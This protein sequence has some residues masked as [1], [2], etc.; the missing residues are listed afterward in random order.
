MRA[1][2]IV[3]LAACHGS[4]SESPPEAS[5]AQC[6]GGDTIVTRKIAYACGSPFAPAAPG[7]MQGGLTLVTSPPNDGRMF[8]L[9]QQGRIRI[10]TEDERI[11]GEPF[12]D[13]SADHGGP[14]A[15]GGEL[16]LLG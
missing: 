16:G 5:I 10:I 1:W 7:C 11:V 8:V 9:E 2:S 6:G 4:S 14:V 15:A 12:L 3:L 13:L